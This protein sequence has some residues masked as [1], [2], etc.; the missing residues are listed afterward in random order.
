MKF[1]NEQIEEL[2][3]EA[4]SNIIGFFYANGKGMK[5]IFQPDL[6]SQINEGNNEAAGFILRSTFSS[7]DVIEE[8]KN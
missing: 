7:F 3:E 8:D 2:K 5:V 4:G 1:T 6:V